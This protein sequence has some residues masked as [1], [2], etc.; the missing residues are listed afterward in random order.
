MRC[1][2]KGVNHTLMATSKWRGK[3]TKPQYPETP[4]YCSGRGSYLEIRDGQLHNR[5]TAHFC[6]HSNHAGFI[7]YRKYP[8]CHAILQYHFQ[9]LGKFKSGRGLTLD[10]RHLTVFCRLFTPK[11]CKSCKNCKSAPRA[12]FLGKIKVGKMGPSYPLRQPIRK[13][14]SLHISQGRCQLYKKIRLLASDN[15]LLNPDE[16]PYLSV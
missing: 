8:E 14:D 11:L 6:L 2:H 12:F 16:K 13:Q 1:G 3:K 9:G 15:R 10:M 7:R 4:A 5:L